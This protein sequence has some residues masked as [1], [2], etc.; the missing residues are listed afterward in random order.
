MNVYVVLPL[1]TAITCII[2]IG[3]VVTRSATAVYRVFVSYLVA[4]MMW[5]ICSFIL[6]SDFFPNQIT[7]W[8]G[9]YLVAASATG[10]L[11]YHFIRTFLGKPA[12]IVTY[13]GYVG[14]AGLVIFISMGAVLKAPDVVNGAL[15]YNNGFLFYL[16]GLIHIA[17]LGMA[18]FSLVWAFKRAGD[19]YVRNRIGYLLAAIPIL[20]LYMGINCI[21]VLGKYVIDGIGHVFNALIISYAIL[22]PRQAEIIFVIRRV[23]TY[24]L[25]VVFICGSFTS[26]MYL[27]Y[28][29]LT[30]LTF[31]SIALLLSSSALLLALAARPLRLVIQER[32][33]R[34]F[35]GGMHRYREELLNFAGTIGNIL[36]L[37]ELA[38]EILPKM[39]K[40]LLIRQVR[41]LVEDDE[42]D[43][44]V[45]FSYPKMEEESGNGLRFSTNSPVVI[46]LGKESYPLE[47]RR[48]DGIL[49]FNNLSVPEKEQINTDGLDL[50]CPIKSRG[51]LVG[52]LAL[53]E[54]QSGNPY[55]YQD[56]QLIMSMTGQVG[57]MIEN[58]RLYSR[59]LSLA[60]T[61]G[62]TGLY[63]HRHLHK[64]MDQEIARCSRYNAVFSLIILDMD[65]FK[66][67]N[68]TFGHLAG[69]K[70]LR[71][72]GECILKSIRTADT[73]FRYGGEEFAVILPETRI[74]N[75]YIVAERIRKEIEQR[76]SPGEMSATASLGIASWPLDGVTKEEVIARADAA[77]YLAKQTGRNKTCLSAEVVGR[78]QFADAQDEGKAKTANTG[79]AL[80]AAIEAKDHYTY[81]HSKKVSD[82]SI[83]IGEALGLTP[84]NIAVIRTAGLLH[85]V[86]KIGIPDSALKKNGP[87][88]DEEW[89]V[90]K[91]H[92]KSGVEIVR[93]IV[94]LNPC[95]PAILHH[96]EH[97][98]GKGYPHG[99]KGKNIP[100]E[101]RILAIADAYDA[102][103]SARS[104][105]K[106]PLSS[107]EAFDELRRCSGTQFDPTL[108]KIFSRIVTSNPSLVQR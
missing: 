89:K 53:G 8:Y 103:T 52:I 33:D 10:I 97:L 27:V 14:L 78:D 49:E 104:Y 61:D 30:N 67:Y 15:Y 60:I 99:L 17:Y 9:C 72:V 107:E 18:M 20:M 32:V 4:L 93:Q 13:L 46:W 34:V 39:S 94:E 21:P 85:D 98:N 40:A 68:D 5:G 6:R 1:I 79:Y 83:A 16:S 42:G 47:V 38:S 65:L 57:L 106:H 31:Y 80:V 62:L 45:Q 50:L 90:V 29:F 70:C 3:I 37:D 63:N 73:A 12:G 51:K 87:L 77:L 26:L 88:T 108:V 75:A 69:D 81:G 95:L 41:L 92:P 76:Q 59:A 91:L 82:Y 43:L 7:L 24:L 64:I 102:L 22:K 35:F 66:A 100:L 19:P 2:I 105:R 84:N 28:R 48:I 55:T 86:G 44:T 71:E 36:D 54:K 11:F 96:H 58:A 25:I 101:S 23:L 74:E 56:I